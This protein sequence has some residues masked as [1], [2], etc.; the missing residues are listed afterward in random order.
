M[1]QFGQLTISLVHRIGFK[2]QRHSLLE[3]GVDCA[4]SG[5]GGKIG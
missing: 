3:K 5:C 2:S 4:E 1:L